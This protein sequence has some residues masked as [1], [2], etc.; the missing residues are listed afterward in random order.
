MPEHQLN[1]PDVDA[2]R[3]ESTRAF[4]P[5]VVPMEIDPLELLAIPLGAFPRRSRHDAQD[6][7]SDS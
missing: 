3:Q 5:E 2:I 6:V 4:M 7:P 1:D